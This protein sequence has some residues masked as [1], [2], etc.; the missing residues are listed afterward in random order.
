LDSRLCG[1]NDLILLVY[2]E[3]NM[4]LSGRIKQFESLFNKAGLLK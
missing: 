2:A 3:T 4:V 1:G